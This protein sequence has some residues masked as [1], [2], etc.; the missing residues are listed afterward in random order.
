M[1]THKR[2]L[3][4]LPAA[5]APSSVASAEPR[6]RFASRMSRMPVSA[7]RELLKVTE[8]PE[9]ISFAGGLPAP[10]LFPVEAIAR[11][12]AEV[13][14]NEGRTALQYSTTEGCRPLREWIASRMQPRGIAAPA[15]RILIT[16][17]AQQ[18]IDLT[19]KI[20]LEPGDLVVVENPTYLAAIQAF[21]GYEAGFVPIE[22][23]HDGMLV[24][25][26]EETLKQTRPKLIYIVS[27]F[28]N[29]KGTTLSHERRIKLIELSERHGVP[30]LEDNPYA[31]LRYEG[32]RLPPLAA[33]DTKGMVIH[34]GSFSKTLSPGMRLGWLTASEKVFQ[35]AVIAKQASD[36]HTSTVEQRAAARL[37]Q[38]FDYD[39]HVGHLCKVYGER[40]LAMRSAIE[41]HF[42]VEVKSTRPEGGL[43]LWVELPERISA[44]EIFN[45][46]IAE[47]VAFV[48]GTSFFAC[49]PRV[50]FMR[51]NFS[52]QQPEMIEEGIRRIGKVIERRLG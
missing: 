36:L 3:E 23:D 35:N 32:N 17:G 39:G 9:I 19:A 29:P 46:A 22:T 38:S 49:E 1:V 28:S 21:S 51:L 43:F 16:S 4:K 25:Q 18:G 24:D 15:E 2:A 13:F 6:L 40:C 30:I 27:E 7:I 8:H 5:T 50:N 37:L 31:E 20:F 48:P 52:N 10:E 44:E 14:S 12:H 42:P 41:R 45:D 33:L 11:A 47:R 26:L 34:L